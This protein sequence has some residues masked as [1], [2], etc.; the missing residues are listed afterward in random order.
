[1]AQDLFQNDLHVAGALSCNSFTPPASCITNNS[2]VAAALI[3]RTK[4]VHQ[5]ALPYYQAPGSDIA[6]ATADI[7]IARATGSVVSFEAAVTGTAATGD[8]SV[9]VDL[10]KSTGGAAFA[11]VLSAAITLNSSDTIRVNDAATISS[12]SYVDGDLFRVVVTQVAGTTGT[13]PQGLVVT[14]TMSENPQ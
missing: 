14:L 6:T 13:R 11:T 4:L 3:D 12:A 9:T 2:V 5:L 7:Y 10:H 8:R 1:M